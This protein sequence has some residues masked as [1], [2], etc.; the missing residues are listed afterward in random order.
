MKY[1]NIDSWDGRRKMNH[2][3]GQNDQLCSHQ[4]RIVSWPANCLGNDKFMILL[5]YLKSTPTRTP[6]GVCGRGNEVSDK[7]YIVTCARLSNPRNT[8]TMLILF[9]YIIWVFRE[10]SWTNSVL[11]QGF[12]PWNTSFWRKNAMQI[13]KK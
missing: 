12:S 10:L 5:L 4:C 8:Y 9:E 2:V 1:K 3:C 6:D 7:V 13:T 11:R